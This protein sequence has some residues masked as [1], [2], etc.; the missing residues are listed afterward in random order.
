MDHHVVTLLKVPQQ[1]L[2]RTMIETEVPMLAMVGAVVAISVS[3]FL[4]IGSLPENPCG[5]LT[6]QEVS[7]ATGLVVIEVER[8]P[9]ILELIRAQEESRNPGPGTICSYRTRSEFG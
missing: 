7:L 9:D 8:V 6:T 2:S 3:T 5:L 4:Q 1:E